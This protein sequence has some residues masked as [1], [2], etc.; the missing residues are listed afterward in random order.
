MTDLTVRN[1]FFTDE[2]VKINWFD[3][4]KIIFTDKSVK[5]QITDSISVNL[6]DLDLESGA[7]DFM[8]FYQFSLTILIYIN[9]IIFSYAKWWLDLK[10]GIQNSLDIFCIWESVMNFVFSS[11]KFIRNVY[12]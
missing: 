10:S 3:S 2:S 5:G 4:K 6:T 1:I 7:D 12:F 8:A 11:I 9:V